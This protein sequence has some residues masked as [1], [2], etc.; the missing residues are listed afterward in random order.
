[1]DACSCSSQQEGLG[2]L[3]STQWDHRA[4]SSHHPLASTYTPLATF[5]LQVRAPLL[6]ARFALGLSPSS[7][8][9]SGKSLTLSKVYFLICKMGMMVKAPI[10]MRIGWDKLPVWHAVWCWAQGLASK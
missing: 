6:P 3:E 7:C 8:V 4:V 10:L 1:M 5:L 9:T 2:V